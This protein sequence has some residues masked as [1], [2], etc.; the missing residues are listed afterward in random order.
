MTKAPKMT[1]VAREAGVSPMTVSRAFR[2]ESSVSDATRVKVRQAAEALGYV[3]DTTASNLRSQ[4]TGFVAV[5]IPSLNNANFASTV[6]GLTMG[7]QGSDLQI[8]LGYTNYDKDE[9]ERLIGQLLG[10]RPEAVVVTGGKHTDKT[11]RMLE[12]SGAPVVETWDMPEN[13]I[14]H[15][16]GFSNAATMLAMVTHLFEQGYRK[17][18][19]IGGDAD[20]D[21]RGSDRR[22]GFVNAMN[23]NG[24][25]PRRLIAAGTPPI[26][27]REGAGSMAE[28]L[29]RF[30]D[31]QAVICVSDLSAF[32]ALTECQRRGIAVPA[33]IAIAGFGNYEISGIAVP[34]LTT[35]DAHATRIGQEAA[36][37]IRRLLSEKASGDTAK[38]IE[39][40]PTLLVRQSTLR[41]DQGSGSD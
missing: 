11:R 18:G 9:E 20:Q 38:V 41:T 30:P 40:E 34:T 12:N 5:T 22:R 36:A 17:I 32:G 35:I 23:S 15:V 4:R 33:G 3:F 7:L 16:V 2:P 25:D 24:L 39:V 19:F 13:P 8:L 27:M 21:T 1:D 29:E 26:S 10:R 28:L 31:T 37:L 6:S 14:D